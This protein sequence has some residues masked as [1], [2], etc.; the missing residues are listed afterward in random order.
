MLP[1][2]HMVYGY[3]FLC[4]KCHWEVILVKSGNAWVDQRGNFGYSMHPGNEPIGIPQGEWHDMIYDSVL[5][6]HCVKE[7]FL[8]IR[9]SNWP[10]IRFQKPQGSQDMVYIIP[11]KEISS[12]DPK[13]LNGSNSSHETRCPDCGNI[14]W[15]G[16]DLMKRCRGRER[17]NRYK[18]NPI[19]PEYPGELCPKCKEVELWFEGLSIS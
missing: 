9:E 7:F 1:T 4:S 16:F 19:P 12:S 2:I 15:G 5:C 17:S 13:N 6:L 18:L 10:I 14:L 8:L 3:H 11:G